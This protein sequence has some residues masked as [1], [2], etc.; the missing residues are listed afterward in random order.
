V[1]EGDGVEAEKGKR[2][3]YKIQYCMEF[4]KVRKE[5]MRMVGNEKGNSC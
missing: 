2:D 5:G 4:R 3:V 1:G